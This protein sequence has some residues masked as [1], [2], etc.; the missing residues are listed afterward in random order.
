MYKTLVHVKNAEEAKAKSL[1]VP[2]DCKWCKC[3]FHGSA[4]RTFTFCRKCGERYEIHFKEDP[5]LG[6][7]EMRVEIIVV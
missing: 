7:E 1:P 3:H 5:E 2:L 4:D 6:D